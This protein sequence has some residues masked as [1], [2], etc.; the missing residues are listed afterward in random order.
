MR[1]SSS[2]CWESLPPVLISPSA[3]SRSARRRPA[4]RSAA[5]ARLRL[6]LGVAARLLDLGGQ[7]GG[8]P[9]E[10]VD[11]LQRRQQAG[12]DR[13]GVVE[14][15]DGRALDARIRVGD[16]LLDLGV[17]LGAGGL[18]RGELLL[19]PGRRL[20]RAEDD[21]RAGGAPALP[22][23]RLV[24][25]R[26]AQRAHDD[27]VLLAHAQQHEV[28][29][30]LEA[31]VLEEQRE[32]EALVELDGDEHGL[33]RER[34]AV[35]AQPLHLH[36]ARRGR[37][38][39]GL[40]EAAPGLGVGGERALDE[41]VEERLAEDL[42]RGAAEQQLGGLGPLG[43]GPLPVREHEVAADDLLQ[44]RVER[45]DDGVFRRRG[46]D[47]V[48]AAGDVGAHA[49]SIGRSPKTVNHSS[50][51]TAAARESSDADP[52]ARPASRV[53]KRSS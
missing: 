50:R 19:D 29:R 4:S 46:E 31:E 53:V 5:S 43:D 52:P 37:R 35:G 36:L 51:S 47:L 13:G 28:E 33:E 9:L 6:R 21:E 17:G 2:R 10:V 34:A 41:R 16:A 30:E 8:H 11:A 26:L 22:R 45:V 42:L 3:R 24:L 23:L 32:V 20:G 49:P 7:A 1:A 15:A 12:D 25:D 39:A 44:Q 27:R 40:E 48:G 38:V 18:A 14:V